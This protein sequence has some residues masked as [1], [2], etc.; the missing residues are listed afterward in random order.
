MFFIR[1]LSIRNTRLKVGK[2]KETF[3]NHRQAELQ[4]DVFYKKLVY[5]KHEAEIR[6]KLRNI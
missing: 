2:K 6:Q 5:K 1:N 4:I 3:Q